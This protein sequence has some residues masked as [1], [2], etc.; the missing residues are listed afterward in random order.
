MVHLGQVDLAGLERDFPLPAQVF[1]PPA[2]CPHFPSKRILGVAEVSQ[3][4]SVFYGQVDVVAVPVFPSR[5]KGHS[6]AE[7]ELVRPAVE[8]RHRVGDRFVHDFPQAAAAG[9]QR[10]NFVAH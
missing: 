4:G 3:A 5:G 1:G 9:L 10:Q 2:R 7:P 6:A 8:L